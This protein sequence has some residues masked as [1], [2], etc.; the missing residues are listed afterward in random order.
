MRDLVRKM[1]AAR[2]SATLAIVVL[3][4]CQPQEQDSIL[5]SDGVQAMLRTNALLT[6]LNER[7]A[8]PVSEEGV[9]KSTICVVRNATA[10]EIGILS[11]DMT[12]DSEIDLALSTIRTISQR[13]ETAA[14]LAA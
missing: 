6:V 13:P 10:K 5:S 12:A 9:R 7:N 14:C 1:R 2:I 8:S 3:A 4:G 11:S